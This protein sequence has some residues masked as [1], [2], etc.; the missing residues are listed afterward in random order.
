ASATRRSEAALW[1]RALTPCGSVGLLTAE[2]PGDGTIRPPAGL[3]RRRTPS[4]RQHARPTLSLPW[5]RR[6]SLRRRL[7][8]SQGRTRGRRESAA[9]KARDSWLDGTPVH[10]QE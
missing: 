8:P 3:E 7:D 10:P 4:A 2:P 9:E 6:C 1:R 5:S